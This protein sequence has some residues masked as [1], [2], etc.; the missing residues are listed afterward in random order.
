MSY[1][2]FF[3][4]VFNI[5]C[6]YLTAKGKVL[7]WPVG[8]VGVVFYLFLFYQI[9]LYSDFT[10]QIY[11]LITS[12]GGWYLWLHPRNEAE[13]DKNKE[14]KVSFNGLKSNVI[15][16]IVIAT[17]TAAMT[18]FMAHINIYFPTLFPEPASYPFLDAFTTVMSFAATILMMKK[19]VE[20]WYL[21]ILVDIIGIGLYFVKEVRFISL[22]YL[23]FL[24]LAT[25]GLISWRNDYN[26]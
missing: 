4:T 21:W 24:V 20:C 19:K 10:E 5:W 16:L 22:E 13:T 11:Y 25:K 15:Y 3:G 26:K 12:F 7:S 14:L 9:R 6:V 23:I 1:L 17:G 8:I 18:Y 2:E